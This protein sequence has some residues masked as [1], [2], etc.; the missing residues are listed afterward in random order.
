MRV[1]IEDNPRLEYLREKTRGLTT[2]PGCYIMKNH[3]G[4]I[5]YIGKAKNLR[6]R[7]STYFHDNDHLPKV[8]KMVSNVWDYDFICTSSDYEALVLEASLI[9]Q[10]K[11]KYNILL[12]DDKGYSYIKIS[13]EDYPRI[14]REMQKKGPGTFIGPYTSGFISSQAVEEV[15]RVFMLPTCKKVFPRDFGK[16]RPCLNFQI[17]R[18]I[19]LCRGCFSKEDYAEIINQAVD[20][21]KSGSKQSVE[22]L[23]DEMNRLSENLEFEKA[24]VIRDRIAAIT[25]SADTQKIF[26]ENMPDTDIFALAKNGGIT[27]ISVLNYRM[28]RLYD[29]QDFILGETTD[30]ISTREEFLIQYYDRAVKIPR[31]IYIDEELR[32]TDNVRRFLAEKSG[33]AVSIANPKRGEMKGLLDLAEKNAVEQLSVRIGR[34]GKE[35]AVLEELGELLGLTKTPN[36]IECYD[37]SN[38]GSTDMVAGMVVMDKCRFAKKYY[39]KF[40]IK[41]VVE[42][43]DYASMR[44]VISRR[45]E[46]YLDPEC[47]DEGFKRLPDV[48]FLDGGKGHVSAVLPLLEEYHVDIPLF[49]LVKD[50]KHHTRAVVTADG[51]E[52]QIS[53]SRSVFALL[54]KLQDEVHRYT[55]T[56]QK[57]KRS[58]HTHETELTKIYGIGEK[59]AQALLNEF[60]TKQQLKSATIEDIAAVMKI[61][62]EKAQEVKEKFIDQ[63]Q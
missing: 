53:K 57:Q 26:E 56:F 15:N 16:E 19:G 13:D 47:K 40:N 24:A 32:E 38:L 35:V 1:T 41:T 39:K 31:E 59:K 36:Y 21:I 7:V 42:Q 9:K 14:T 5:I 18:C 2:S 20:Y 33:H 10:H 4:T 8:A 6:N 62:P 22:E 49:G 43:N 17:K 34:T 63:L 61:S 51:S 60:K 45:L 23:T 55:I 28:G 37:I 12:K 3:A 46:N 27:C 25:R 30:D 58:T 44:E 52:I 29:K 54:T 50:N 11:P 48:I